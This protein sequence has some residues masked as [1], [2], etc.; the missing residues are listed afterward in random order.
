VDKHRFLHVGGAIPQTVP[1]SVSYGK[2]GEFA[3]FFPWNPHPVKDVGMILDVNY[4]PTMASDDRAELVRA[5]IEPSG[6]DPE[7]KV[8]GEVSVEIS[9][10]DREHAL[11]LKDLNLIQENIVGI[12]NGFR[13]RFDVMVRLP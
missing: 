6:P 3:G 1:I 10:S 7:M 4:V 13:P 2:K 9:L 11:I 12:V 8:Q 5:L